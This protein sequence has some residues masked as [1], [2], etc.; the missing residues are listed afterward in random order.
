MQCHCGKNAISRGL[1]R[2]HYSQQ[3]RAG[4]F[5]GT[6]TDTEPQ[7]SSTCSECGK[8]SRARGLCVTHYQQWRRTYTG[9][10]RRQR[11][12]VCTDNLPHAW[13]AGTC[14]ICGV[15]RPGEWV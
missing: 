1:C 6:P 7:R 14:R 11:M 8:P 5:H 3:Y 10:G 9:K 12:G 2:T 13:N 4:Q 15:A